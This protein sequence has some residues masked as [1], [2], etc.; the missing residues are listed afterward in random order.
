MCA[1]E[2]KKNR[3]ISTDLLNRFSGDMFF[4]ILFL[5]FLCKRRPF[6]YIIIYTYYTLVSIYKRPSY[7]RCVFGVG[8][9]VK[10]KTRAQFSITR[11]P[12][13][14]VLWWFFFTL[15]LFYLT[16]EKHPLSTI[17]KNWSVPDTSARAHTQESMYWKIFTVFFFFLR[18]FK[19]LVRGLTASMRVNGGFFSCFLHK[20]TLI[21]VKALKQKRSENTAVA[22]S[23][24]TV[25]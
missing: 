24:N 5:F 12:I 18:D 13:Y 23:T 17:A 22:W 25:L 8:S 20:K 19:K 14:C 7:T 4:Y 3:S 6:S 16:F 11:T 15:F 9:R 21:I 10:N 2:E 1:R